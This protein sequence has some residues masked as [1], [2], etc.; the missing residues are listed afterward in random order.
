LPQG[1]LGGPAIDT[2]R[3]RDFPIRQSSCNIP[4]TAQAYSLNFTAVPSGRLGYLTT[5]PTGSSQPF[6]STLNSP[7]T[8]VANAAIVPAGTNG[9]ISVFATDPTNVVID[10]NGYFAPPGAQGAMSFYAVSPCR[11]L[12]TRG[13]AGALGG[14]TMTATQTR[15]YPVPSSACSV[16][17]TAQAYS[18][19]ATVV[20]TNAGLGYLTLWPAGSAQPFV[21]TLNALD[22]SIT[23]NAALVPAGTTGG[24]SAFVTERTDLILD[25][26][27]YFAP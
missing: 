25:I 12:D 20:P 15:T 24:V 18:L 26:N 23:A 14:P 2:G 11:V 27:G 22:G 6:V 8:V 16:P 5:W 7:G 3:S 10:I 17:P 13:G 21:S 1:S 19:N 9:A 4:A